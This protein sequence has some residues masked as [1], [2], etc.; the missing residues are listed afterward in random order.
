MSR[1]QTRKPSSASGKAPSRMVSTDAPHRG[2]IWLVALGA[3]RAGVPG[4]TAP[5]IVVSVDELSTGAR[6]SKDLHDHW[7]GHRQRAAGGLAA[8]QTRWSRRRQKVTFG[9]RT[10]PRQDPRANT[11]K[12]LSGE[13][14]IA[15]GDFDWSPR[16]P[17]HRN[18][19]ML[20]G[21]AGCQPH[22][23]VPEGHHA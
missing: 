20:R 1:V 15:A 4:K 13:V 18:Q 8:R 9:S 19:A 22:S 17:K 2:D 6:A 14:S 10:I 21:P 16:P 23:D 3:G 7:F 11:D 12:S 5:A